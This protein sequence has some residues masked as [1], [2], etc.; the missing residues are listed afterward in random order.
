M[1]QNKIINESTNR[2][3][4]L[5]SENENLNSTIISIKN[6]YDSATMNKINLLR[7]LE[8]KLLISQSEKYNTENKLTNELK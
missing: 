6:E 8:E 7:E 4:L 5:S 2:I 3:Q 1:S